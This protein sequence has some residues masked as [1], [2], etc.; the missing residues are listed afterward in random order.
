MTAASLVIVFHFWVWLVQGSITIALFTAA[1]L[2]SGWQAIGCIVLLLFI[3]RFGTP[4]SVPA[5]A[6]VMNWPVVLGVIIR[7]W[8]GDR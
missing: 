8:K 1:L 4:T 6:M 5:L 3:V 2:A 7:H